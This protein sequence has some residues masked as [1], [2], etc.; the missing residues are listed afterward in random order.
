MGQDFWNPEDLVMDCENELFTAP[1]QESEVKEAVWSCYADGAPGPDG[2]SFIL[3]LIK[4]D[5][6][7]MF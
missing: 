6:M 3:D 7:H 1:F 4:F 5:L 2:L